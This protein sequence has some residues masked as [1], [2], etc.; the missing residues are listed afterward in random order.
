MNELDD[1][2]LKQLQLHKEWIDSVGKLGKQLISM[3]AQ[4]RSINLSDRELCE[5]ILPMALLDNANLVRTD[6]YAANL[7]S[8]SFLN[9]NLEHTIFIKANLDHA[10]LMHCNLRYA[11]LLKATFVEANL[12]NSDLTEANLTRAYLRLTNLEGTC[13]RNANL[14]EADLDGTRFVNA[15]IVGIKGFDTIYGNEIIV[16]GQE[17]EITIS[18]TENIRKWLKKASESTQ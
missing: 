10:Q 14:T 2:L 18:G 12:A 3:N 11:N 13:L 7:A 15:D 8:A 16:S 9:A 5:A 1:A 4:L 17:T 6:F